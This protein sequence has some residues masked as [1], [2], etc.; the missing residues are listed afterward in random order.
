MRG[1]DFVIKYDPENDPPIE[2][3]GDRILQAILARRLD[4]NKPVIFYIT[5]ESGEGK[6]WS[7]LR[8]IELLNDYYHFDA[9]PETV[10]EWQVIYTPLEYSRKMEKLLFDKAFHS[11]RGYLIDEAREIIG[12]DNWQSFQNL[13]ISNVTAVHREI[14]PMACI[15]TSQSLKDLDRRMRERVQFQAT[16]YRPIEESPRLYIRR[17]WIDEADP[18]NVKLRKRRL[19]GYIYLPDGSRRLVYIDHFIVGRPSKALIKAYRARSRPAKEQFI[20]RMLNELLERLEKQLGARVKK[21]EEIAEHLVENKA[22]FLAVGKVTNKGNVRLNREKVMLIYGL[23][24]KE[25]KEL[26]RLIQ[27]KLVEKGVVANE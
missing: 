3:M 13:A 10:A 25:V 22:A 17:F 24:R 6:S 4:H 11:A 14:K 26:E 19:R 27:L 23:D 21:L 2:E 7:G 20:R 8:I 18:E 1:V 12:A 5:G 15:I 16:A 9:D